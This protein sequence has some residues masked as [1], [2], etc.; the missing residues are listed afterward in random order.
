M[1]HRKYFQEYLQSQIVPSLDSISWELT[2]KLYHVLLRLFDGKVAET[3]NGSQE[4]GGVSAPDHRM[5]LSNSVRSL[6]FQVFKEAHELSLLMHKH[7]VGYD[8]NL[9]AWP[10]K[11]VA[12]EMWTLE[13]QFPHADGQISVCVCPR[14]SHKDSLE[15]IVPA[16]VLLL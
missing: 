2:D 9:P 16:L 6:L 15:T 11:F 10:E 5:N 3:E 8:V 14:L 4:L 12:E 7:P 13:H 1:L